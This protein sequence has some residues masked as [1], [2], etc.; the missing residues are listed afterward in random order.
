MFFSK[1]IRC[2]FSNDVHMKNTNIHVCF[3]ILYKQGR[4][5]SSDSDPI[6]TT[7][8]VDSTFIQFVSSSKK[9]PYPLFPPP[10]G[11]C[12]GPWQPSPPW[13]GPWRWLPQLPSPA[14]PAPGSE[15]RRHCLTR[16]PVTGGRRECYRRP[17][18]SIDCAAKAGTFGENLTWDAALLVNCSRSACSVLCCSSYTTSLAS[19][20]SSR[21][22]QT[23][24]D[25]AD[26]IV[27]NWRLT[28]GESNLQR[29]Y[30]VLVFTVLCFEL[31]ILLH[32]PEVFLS[33]LLQR[34]DATPQGGQVWG[35]TSSLKGAK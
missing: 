22:H 23:H 33:L 21:K 26:L 11:W 10:C 1:Q 28:A 34:C 15:C 2:A 6:K 14:T 32:F 18:M 20:I 13:P 17:S 24:N 4:I 35:G 29:N 3:N 27:V 19:S 31:L 25:V 9:Q 8:P 16:S 7:E 30:G 5:G 12:G